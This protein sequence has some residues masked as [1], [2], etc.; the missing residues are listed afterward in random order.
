MAERYT[1]ITS[2][3]TSMY[4]SMP[5]RQ[6]SHVT[7]FVDQKFEPCLAEVFHLGSEKKSFVPVDN[8][9]SPEFNNV[10]YFDMAVT[11]TAS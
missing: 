11:F 7:G 2:P 8:L 6:F 4:R 3:R 1:S 5:Y 9:D 10:I